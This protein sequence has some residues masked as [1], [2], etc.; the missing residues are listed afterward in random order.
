MNYYYRLYLDVLKKNYMLVII[1]SM[2][3]F[4]TFFIW[5]GIP[6]YV[7]GSVLSDLITSKYLISLGVSLSG[8]LLFS[9]YFLPINLKVAR[10]IAIE[11]N[12]SISH[13]F[14]RLVIGWVLVGAL[15]FGLVIGIL[16]AF[17]G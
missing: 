6:F 10:N 17:V 5:I 7:V 3:L 2:L 15:I 9:L 1:A 8:G 4:P 13:S 11:R 14:L 16:G 12:V